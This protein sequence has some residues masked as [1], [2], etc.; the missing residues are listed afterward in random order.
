MFAVA[1]CIDL[2]RMNNISVYPIRS[3]V[4]CI[5]APL[6]SREIFEQNQ[7]SVE[8]LVEL[9]AFQ[10]T[11]KMPPLE[12]KHLTVDINA[13]LKA[14]RTEYEAK[15]NANT[16]IPAVNYFGA[17]ANVFLRLKDP[18]T[19]FVQPNFFKNFKVYFPFYLENRNG[20]FYA[21]DYPAT[22]PSFQDIQNS[23][24]SLY[25]P[26]ELNPNDRIFKINGQDPLQYLTYFANKYDY[27]SK[28]EHGRVN[29]HLHGALFAKRLDIYTMPEQQDQKFVFEFASG[30]R[31]TVNLVVKVAAPVLSS[32]AAIDMYNAEI[33]KKKN[34]YT[35]EVKMVKRSA[36]P[37]TPY[38]L[39]EHHEA[40][41][42][43]SPVKEDPAFEQVLVSPEYFVLYKF[44]KNEV[45]KTFDYVLSIT[46]FSPEDIA[47]SLQDTIKLLNLIDGLDS[48]S[49]LYISV[50]S[51]GGGWV[52]L[53]HL[54]AV[55][56]FHTEYPIYGRYNIR[57]SKLAELLLK[58][59]SEFEDMHRLEWLTGKTLTHQ[60]STGK[61]INMEW[62]EPTVEE[63]F[64]QYYAFD[65]DQDPQVAALSKQIYAHVSKLN[66]SQ[67][68][69]LTDSQCGSTCSCFSKH[70]LQMQN[71]Y[72]IGFGGAYNSVDA[73][74]V[75]SFAG[76]AVMDSDAYEESVMHLRANKYPNLSQDEINT[77][78]T[79]WIPHGG[80]LRFAHHIIYDFDPRIEPAQQLEY[81]SIKVNQVINTYPSF[82]DW[83]GLTGLKTIIPLA[84]KATQNMETLD[85]YGEECGTC[86]TGVISRMKQGK[87]VQ[88]GCA[89][90]YY[91]AS[92]TAIT[93]CDFE[94]IERH[95]R[96][97]PG[98]IEE[99]EEQNHSGLGTGAIVG[100]VIG[101]VAGVAVLGAIV[102]FLVKPQLFKRKVVETN[103]DEVNSLVKNEA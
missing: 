34:P 86:G 21:N 18:H 75:G 62:Y 60:A 99:E 9:H 43:A 29:S 52:S 84:Q 13:E 72:A 59:G 63:H 57:K 38:K 49:K 28:S 25:A 55:G 50:V 3:A 39:F 56:L 80:Y 78:T 64:T 24:E 76:G 96:Y 35:G 69:L 6:L 82:N 101:S 22:S 85:V 41:F 70:L 45:T 19:L 8:N 30:K 71:V 102:L 58:S 2:C 95:D 103:L 36:G 27:S 15:L 32:Q 88:F 65:D 66:P 98:Y 42:T 10:E 89:Y 77:L 90:G 100:I 79:N 20:F 97:T 94:C 54:L 83:Q 26:M 33:A 87:C 47:V 11:A 17:L 7:L 37:K 91:R 23:Y 12:Y 61:K 46:S 5:N 16:A 67:V 53:G 4:E 51:N 1:L 44:N 68:I 40:L 14:I 74:D 48:K 73:F 31:L 81:K 93:Q 92:A